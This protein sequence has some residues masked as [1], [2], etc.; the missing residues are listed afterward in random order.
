MP[1]DFNHHIL[2]EQAHRPWPRPARPWFMTQ[3]WH[4]LVFAHWPLPAAVMAPR[5]PAGIELDLFDGQAW[6][7]IVP[8]R[9]SNVALRG[10]PAL[11]MFPELNLRT[12]VRVGDKPGVLFFSLDATN[13]LAVATARTLFRLPYHWASM[14]MATPDGTIR[15]HS[16]RS[17]RD[18]R[19]RFVAT[20][21]PIGD[22][23]TARPGTLEYF[24][25]ERYCL[26]TTRGGSP[27]IVEIHH[28]PWPLQVAR[29]NLEVNTMAHAAG[30]E[31]S[32][33]PHLL[34]FAKR[35]DVVAWTPSRCQ[36]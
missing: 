18:T 5:I 20:Y 35:Q 30:I 6:L 1:G 31:L 9:M 16:R 14:A 7:G 19:A 8:F 3:T 32:G 13:L 26:Y 28:P 15:Y 21:G 29:A 2:D 23:F 22:V 25:T 4:D 27:L 24:L 36:P 34:H 33:P 12:Y 17:R 10:L 11:P